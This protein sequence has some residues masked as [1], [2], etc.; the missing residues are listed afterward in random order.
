M[1]PMNDFYFRNYQQPQIKTY[2][3]TNIEEARASII[4]PLA[5]NLFIDTSTGN[6]YLKKLG[7]DGR[8][9]FLVYTIQEEVV[10]DPMEEIKI[11]LTNIENRLGGNNDKSVSNDGKSDTGNKS[12]VAKQNVANDEVKSAGISEDAGNDEWEK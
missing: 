11:R 5:T 2:F 8:P 12:T 10:K 9:Q 1:Y 3:V 4:D 7:N 6:I